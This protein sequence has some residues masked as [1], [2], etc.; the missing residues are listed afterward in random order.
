[1]TRVQ[2]I[3]MCLIG[4]LALVAYLQSYEVAKAMRRSGALEFPK[5]FD[6]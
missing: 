2:Y 1:M 5:E 6:V 3:T 4:G